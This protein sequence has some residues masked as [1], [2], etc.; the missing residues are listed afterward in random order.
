MCFDW[1]IECPAYISEAVTSVCCG[2]SQRRLRSSD[3]TNYTTATT[4]TKFREK[5]FSVAGYSFWISLTKHICSATNKHCFKRCLKTY[6]FN[7]HSIMPLAFYWLCNAWPFRTA[8][9]R[10]INNFFLKIINKDV[11]LCQWRQISSSNQI[12]T[13]ISIKH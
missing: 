7:I 3:G 8:V 9:G 10:A 13:K 5:A 2:P 6:Y 4:G 12:E 1:L 11:R